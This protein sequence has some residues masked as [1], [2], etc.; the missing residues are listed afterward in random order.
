MDDNVQHNGCTI[1]NTEREGIGNAYIHVCHVVTSL[2][3]RDGALMGF[4]YGLCALQVHNKASLLCS[5]FNIEYL[6]RSYLDNGI[7]QK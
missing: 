7:C 1:D 4:Y 5:S 2:N 3:D 6:K